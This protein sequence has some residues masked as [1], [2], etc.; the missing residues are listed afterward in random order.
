[1]L[2]CRKLWTVY[3]TAHNTFA[4]VGFAD[5]IWPVVILLRNQLYKLA[6][7]KTCQC[8]VIRLIDNKTIQNGDT[9]NAHLLTTIP[10]E[11]RRILYYVAVFVGHGHTVDIEIGLRCVNLC[12]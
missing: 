8:P 1:M 5:R 3:D 6:R 2:I 10:H 12:L 4:D 11:V 9:L 7:I